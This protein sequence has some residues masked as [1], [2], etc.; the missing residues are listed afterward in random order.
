LSFPDRREQRAFFEEICDA[1]LRLPG[2]SK[3]EGRPGTG[4]VIIT[5]DGTTEAL[6][7]AARSNRAF[8]V[9]EM[10]Q[11][12]AP[13]GDTLDWQALFT[14]A[15]QDTSGPSGAVRSAAIAALLM[16]AIL[17]I[18]RGQIMPP[19]TTALWYALSLLLGKD[20]AS[21]ETGGDGG[22]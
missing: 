10:G 11:Q 21:G 18:T 22:E 8:V 20:M 16:M 5:H 4:S 1:S 3:V 19:A 13:A 17:Q 14:T 15:T 7:Q 9:E 2:V 6:L 12:S